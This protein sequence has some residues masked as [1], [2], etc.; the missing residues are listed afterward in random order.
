MTDPLKIN[1][2]LNTKIQPQGSRLLLNKGKPIVYKFI[3]VQ[4]VYKALKLHNSTLVL[5]WTGIPAAKKPVDKVSM[6]DPVSL[7]VDALQ[8]IKT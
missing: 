6:I 2:T 5:Q 3:G 7:W 8:P 1:Y 4:W